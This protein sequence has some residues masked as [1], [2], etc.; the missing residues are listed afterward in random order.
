MRHE[1]QWNEKED[2]SNGKLGQRL[3]LGGFLLPGSA[4]GGQNHCLKKESLED[5]IRKQTAF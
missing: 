1:K 5:L 3:R 2:Q 4:L